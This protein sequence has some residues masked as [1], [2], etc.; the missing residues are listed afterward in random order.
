VVWVGFVVLVGG[1]GFVSAVVGGVEVFGDTIE[2]WGAEVAS[3]GWGSEPA[4]WAANVWAA[5]A[6]PDRVWEDRV[7]AD[8]V[9]AER[10]R[11]R[12]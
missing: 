7:L 1:L 6:W 4:C 10:E 12:A 3:G 11:W 9:W 5:N 8:R 2:G